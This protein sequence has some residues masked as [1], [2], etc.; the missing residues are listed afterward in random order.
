M[1]KVTFITFAVCLAGAGFGC[2]RSS[3]GASDSGTAVSAAAAPSASVAAADPQPADTA[4]APPPTTTAVS[5]AIESASTVGVREC[6]DYISKWNSCYRDPATRAAAK[7]GLDRTVAA[8]RQTAKDPQSRAGL[9]RGCKTML[10]SFP[11][12]ACGGGSASVGSTGVKECDDYISKWNSCY[13]DPAARA[14]AKPGL[15][16]TV[17]TWR[18]EA[19]NPQSRAGLAK[20]CKT[21]FDNFPTAACK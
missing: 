18:Q 2:T 9:T 11:E 13:R 4:T 8:W 12:A 19:Q 14:A 15:D 6:D 17:S 21:M 7:P 5:A 16:R 1:G 10:D 3:S 20:G